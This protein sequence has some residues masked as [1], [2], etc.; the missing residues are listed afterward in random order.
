MLGAVA[1][2]AVAEK[3]ATQ[4]ATAPK[5]A[6]PATTKPKAASA[7]AKPKAK[8]VV[9]AEKLDDAGSPRRATRVLVIALR[10]AIDG[11]D[12]KLVDA[13]A[14]ALSFT[15][16]AQPPTIA[17]LN[18]IVALDP[19]ANRRDRRARHLELVDELEALVTWDALEDELAYD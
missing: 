8:Q 19:T 5:T 10:K 3:T 15:L 1:Q 16:D 6:K 18:E 2:K 7:K 12:S 14:T 13:V 9:T 17:K 11:V 4:E